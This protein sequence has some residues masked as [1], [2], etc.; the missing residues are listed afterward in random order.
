METKT[1]ERNWGLDL[2]RI[3]AA[4]TVVMLH[5]SPQAYLDVKIVSAPW[6]VMNAITGLCCWNVSAFFM[7]SGAFLLAPQKAMSTRTLYRKNIARLA[8]AFVFWSAVYALTYCLLRG[9]ALA[10]GIGDVLTP[11]PK[12][13]D[14]SVVIAKPKIHVSTAFVYGNLK[15]NELSYHPDIDGQVEAIRDGDFYAMAE[16]M[17]NVLETVT[18]PAYPVIEEI[19]DCM[20]N[21][22]AVNAMM[23]GSGPTVFG[24]FDDRE[25]AKQAYARLRS[26]SI[27]REVYLTKFFHNRREQE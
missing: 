20:K 6:N 12:A 21:C 25:K 24:L 16:K 2:L 11:L 13:P 15:A 5:V 18:I 14:C 8:T 9:T 22:G 17:G 23:S 3:L 27:A 7:L 10:E 1:V 4:F 26:G 19:K